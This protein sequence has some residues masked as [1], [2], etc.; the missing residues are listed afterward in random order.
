[1]RKCLISKNIIN[2]VIVFKGRHVY[3][4]YKENLKR[5]VFSFSIEFTKSEN[6]II[7]S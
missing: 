6:S 5:K 3:F 7:E 2:S 4:D 1:M